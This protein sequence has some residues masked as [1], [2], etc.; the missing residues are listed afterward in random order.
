[1]SCGTFTLSSALLRIRIGLSSQ[2]DILVRETSS[3]SA[4][5]GAPDLAFV[6]HYCGHHLSL[7]F[8]LTAITF[9]FY[10]QMVRPGDILA[11]KYLETAAEA[12]EVIKWLNENYERVWEEAKRS[13][14]DNNK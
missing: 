3:R 2:P 7:W 11:K 12:M 9:T 6:L 10:N 5:S 13:R 4:R 14:V 1:M 8:W